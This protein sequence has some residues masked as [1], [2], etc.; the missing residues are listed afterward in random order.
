MQALVDPD[1]L[2]DAFDNVLTLTLADS[3]PSL[4]LP[5]ALLVA[6]FSGAVGETGLPGP[7]NVAAAELEELRFFL[8]IAFFVKER[9]LTWYIVGEKGDSDDKCRAY[10]DPNICIRGFC[11]GALSVEPNLSASPVELA[12]AVERSWVFDS[13]GEL[14]DMAPR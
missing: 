3:K 8:G 7:T 11:C 4:W 9:V 2:S 1:V 14:T 12:Y 6:P 13:R 5:V 10:S